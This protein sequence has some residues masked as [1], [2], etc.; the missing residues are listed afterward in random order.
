M[1]VWFGHPGFLRSELWSSIQSC[2]PLFI[3]WFPKSACRL[4]I[5]CYC[6][7]FESDPEVIRIIKVINNYQIRKLLIDCQ[8][9]FL[10]QYH[11]IWILMPG[12]ECLRVLFFMWYLYAGSDDNWGSRWPWW[13]W[14]VSDIKFGLFNV[15]V[16]FLW[17]L[18]S[19]L[20]FA[21]FGM[22]AWNVCLC[23]KKASSFIESKLDFLCVLAIMI[24]FL[25]SCCP[26]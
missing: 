24:V 14:R 7:T 25:L 11:R 19:H 23:T 17:M 13:Y 22:W 3:F 9:K 18:S 8:T 26:I 2:N 16:S 20:K 6:L 15:F 1:L 5:S 10:S 4:L 21:A 12:C